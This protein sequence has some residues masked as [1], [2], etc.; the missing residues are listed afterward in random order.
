MYP[1]AHGYT[2]IEPEPWEY[3]LNVQDEIGTKGAPIKW[4][5]SEGLGYVDVEGG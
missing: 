4:A 2:D 5:V 1:V 3:L